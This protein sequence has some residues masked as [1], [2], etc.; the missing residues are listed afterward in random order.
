MLVTCHPTFGQL[1]NFFVGASLE[2]TRR[3]RNN[4]LHFT[5]GCSILLSKN[6]KAPRHRIPFF[7][8][9]FWHLFKYFNSNHNLPSYSLFSRCFSW[10]FYFGVH[11]SAGVFSCFSFFFFFNSPL[12][13]DSRSRSLRA[14]FRLTEKRWKVAP[15]LQIQASSMKGRVRGFFFLVFLHIK[16]GGKDK[17]FFYNDINN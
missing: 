4:K 5:W 17:L 9:W 7:F 2:V 12:V 15:V 1:S 10:F 6:G 3:R 16:T 11:R 13:R 8:Q 14:C